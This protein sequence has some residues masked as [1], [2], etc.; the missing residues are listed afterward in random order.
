VTIAARKEL[1]LKLKLND[2]DQEL[3]RWRRKAAVDSGTGNEADPRLARHHTQVRRITDLLA[4]FRARIQ[5]ETDQ[6]VKDAAGILGR[7]AE[8]ERNLLEVHRL[9]DYFR[10]KLL[11]RLVDDYGERLRALDDFAWACYQPAQARA[12]QAAQVKLTDVKEP[13]LVF[14]YGAGTPLAW[15]RHSV[16]LADRVP[17][18]DFEFDEVQKAQ[19]NL[20]VPVVALPWSHARHLPDALVLGHEVGHLVEEDFKLTNQLAKLLAATKIPMP[21]LG[22]WQA[23][24]SEVFAD[25]WGTLAAGPA[26]T[27]VLADLLAKATRDIQ[28]QRILSNSPGLYPS[29]WLR[30]R[31]S[32]AV[33]EQ[34]DANYAVEAADRLKAWRATYPSHSLG[35][36]AEKDVHLVVSALLGGPYPE[37]NVQR[38]N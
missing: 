2:L 3:G 26:F 19:R 33:L 22:V 34:V 8:L 28:N 30:V 7:C 35:D 24:R 32:V 36:Y 5:H 37:F 13:P 18:E 23:W 16:F 4:G 14:F 17:G 38:G 1:E 20:P 9:W 31:I 27:G 21:R 25:I 15:P 10:S 29:D 11:L 6:A 12:V